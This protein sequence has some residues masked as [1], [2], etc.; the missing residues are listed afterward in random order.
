[1]DFTQPLPAGF[2][3]C[4]GNYSA[5]SWCNTP[6]QNGT[7]PSTQAPLVSPGILPRLISHCNQLLKGSLTQQT[8]DSPW[9]RGSRSV[10]D[11]P[12]ILSSVPTMRTL[13]SLKASMPPCNQSSAAN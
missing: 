9:V 11:Q 8:A 1:M 12:L 13:C 4:V 7:C 5:I 3:I 2:S 10:H 6:L